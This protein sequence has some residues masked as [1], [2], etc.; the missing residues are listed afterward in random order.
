MPAS[1]ARAAPM[2][3]PA[4]LGEAQALAELRGIAAQNRVLKSFI[5]QG[6]HGTHTPGVI[7]RNVLENPAWYTAY[8]PYQAEISQGRLEALVNFQTM[9]C[10]LTGMA[11]AERVDAR[12]SHRRG[13]G[14]DAGA[15]RQRQGKDA[16]RLL[17]RRR[18]AIRR[19]SRCVRTRAAPLGIEV[20]VADSAEAGDAARRRRLLRACSLQYPASSGALHDLQPPTRRDACARRGVSIVAADLLALTLLVPPGELGADIAVGNDAALRHAD[21]LRRPARRLPR[22]PRRVQALAARPAGRRQRRRA[23]PAG[24]PPRA[25]D[26]RAAHPAREGDRNIC[27]AQVLPAVVAEHVRGLPRARRA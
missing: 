21:G 9:V 14:D 19:R 18:R 15:A 1:I 17:R 27:T 6:Y 12:R 20:V 25:A 10:D 16:A 3:L 8:T 7:L 4:P 22:L 24:L 23:R 5:G 2:R 13:R 11:I 26:A